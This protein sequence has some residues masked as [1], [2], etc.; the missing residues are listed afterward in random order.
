MKERES[1]VFVSSCFFA[2]KSIMN[3]DIELLQKGRQ[4]K[5]A[6]DPKKKRAIKI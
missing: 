4:R 5:T 1:V 2:N 3:C 6:T